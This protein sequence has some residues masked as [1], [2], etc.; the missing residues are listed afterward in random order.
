MI[1]YFGEYIRQHGVPPAV[2]ATENLVGIAIPLFYAGK[3]Y[4]FTGIFSSFLG[5]A[6][7]FRIIAFCSLMI[8]FWH[9]KRAAQYAYRKTAASITVA[10]IVTWAIYPL[11]NLYNRN[12]LTEFIAVIFLNSAICCLFVLLFR[13]FHGKK[14]YY[15]AVAIGFFYAIAAV[16]HPLTAVFGAVFVICI[17]TC[18]LFCR[19]RAWF[20]GVGLVN[21]LLIAGVLSSWLYLLQ[22]YAAWLLVTDSS[23]N[24]QYFRKSF[25]DPDSIN[26]PW[27]LFSPTALDLRTLR[28]GITNVST[29]YLD[30]QMNLPLLVIGLAFCYGW[31]ASRQRRFERRQLFLLAV[32]IVSALWFGLALSLMINPSL[33]A[34][35]GGIFDVLQFSYR[36][37]T[38][39]NL[40]ALTFVLATGGLLDSLNVS[41]DRTLAAREAIILGVSLGVS[42]SGLVT[43]LI[44]ANTTRFSDPY[45]DLVRLARLDRLAN[46]PDALRCWFPAFGRQSAMLGILPSTFYGHSQYTV[47]EGFSLVGPAGLAKEARIRFLPA[48]GHQ[49]GIVAPLKLTLQSPTL[50]LTNV[51]PFPWNHIIVNGRELKNDAL[52]ALLDTNWGGARG[53]AGLLELPLRAGEYTIE[54]RFLPTKTWQILEG[55][56]SA[57]L[58]MWL[59]LWV[60]T[61]LRVRDRHARL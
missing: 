14:S 61:A 45:A 33:S 17:G 1:E 44:H 36:L 27:S 30:V 12:A 18:F 2:L 46:I 60:V 51:Q 38:Y 54:Y 8:Q 32:M 55:I 47:L 20:A 4:A 23:I 53:P 34:F 43:K 57:I 10:T 52:V 7:A 37:T 41:R 42:F 39:L 59:L 24:Q 13:N 56:S 26:N 58:V 22:R 21:A 28:N 16:T 19:N 40:A 3:F 48:S 15:D 29:P 35:V 6:V 9:V 25:F 50:L 31:I 5:S 49:F 11:T